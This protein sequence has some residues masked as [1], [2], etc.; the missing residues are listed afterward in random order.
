MSN[1]LAVA[2][3]TAALAQ[4]VSS[5]ISDGR[6]L[7]IPGARVTFLNPSS[8]QLQTGE[9]TVNIFLYRVTRNAGLNNNDLPTRSGDAGFMNRPSAAVDL[10]Y[11]VTFFGDDRELAP[12]RLLGSVVAGLHAEPVLGRR[13]IQDTIDA[14]PWL[15]G[16]DLAEQV[17]SVKVTQAVVEPDLMVRFWTELIKTDYQLSVFYHASVVLLDTPVGVPAALP[18][19][20]VG[21][22]ALPGGD[23]VIGD[24]ANLDLPGSPV[25]AGGGLIGV[26]G[27]DLMDPAV[28]VL[29]GGQPAAVVKRARTA[30]GGQIVVR[31]TQDAAPGLRRGA[32][33]LQLV[34]GASDASEVRTVT[35]VPA[36]ASPPVFD[37]ARRTATASLVPAP[38]P[39]EPVVLLLST[40]GTSDPASRRIEA[41]APAAGAPLTFDLSAVADGTYL[42]WVEVG[43]GPAPSASL[44]T[45]GPDGRYAAPTIVVA[46]SPS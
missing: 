15:K 42:V 46:G 32:V 31:L 20:T 12:Q 45:T 18:V 29:V 14:T 36:F 4:H 35:V 5:F 9:S 40:S 8:E 26:S 27:P 10:D 33:P 2:A 22:A 34:R 16:S 19:R 37:P 7:Q 21:V 39:G 43:A 13:L 23:I 30:E 17:E 25:V 38:Q 28:T 11:L 41:V 24:V 6:P 44:L 3:V 1:P